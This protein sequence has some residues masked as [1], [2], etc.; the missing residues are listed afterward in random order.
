MNADRSK[1]QLLYE[2]PSICDQAHCSNPEWLIPNLC[3]DES[4]VPNDAG[5]LCEISEHSDTC[6]IYEEWIA[7]D[8]IKWTEITDMTLLRNIPPNSIFLSKDAGLFV[9]DKLADYLGLARDSFKW[10]SLETYCESVDASLDEQLAHEYIEYTSKLRSVQSAVK[11]KVSDHLSECSAEAVLRRCQHDKLLQEIDEEEKL[12][13]TESADLEVLDAEYRKFLQ[14]TSEVV[15]VFE[16]LDKEVKSFD[17]KMDDVILEREQLQVMLNGLT[18]YRF[19][20]CIVF[21]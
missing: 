18:Y 15:S 4:V 12:L 17:T 21:V 2:S 3:I 19:I 10:Q 6:I 7:F 13:A 14:E 5:L 8:N 20:Y 16:A 11:K 1:T 9:S